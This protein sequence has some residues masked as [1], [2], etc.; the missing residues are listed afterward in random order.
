MLHSIQS[1]LESGWAIVK[2]ILMGEGKGKF[3][4]SKNMLQ[5]N[6][7]SANYI[8][9]SWCNCITETNI[10]YISILLIITQMQII[11]MIL[12]WRWYKVQWHLIHWVQYL[13]HQNLGNWRNL[14]VS[15]T[16]KEACYFCYFSPFYFCKKC[17]PIVSPIQLLYVIILYT[18]PKAIT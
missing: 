5:G 12:P 9:C 10:T 2:L 8:I 3:S 15:V 4:K 13:L 11:L 18:T 7:I 1:P 14:K 16:K 17:Y 6:A